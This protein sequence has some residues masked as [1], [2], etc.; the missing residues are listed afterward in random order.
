MALS[1]E[2]LRGKPPDS[3]SGILTLR[4]TSVTTGRAEAGPRRVLRGTGARTRRPRPARAP[5]ARWLF[6][7]AVSRVSRQEKV[8]ANWQ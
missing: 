4:Q 6:A 2:D 3:V 8:H 7:R 5:G 1:G